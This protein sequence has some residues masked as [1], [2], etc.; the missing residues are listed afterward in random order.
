MNVLAMVLAGGEGTRLHPLTAE[1]SKPAVTF[2]NGCRIVDFVLSNLVN[3]G[4]TTIYLLAQYKPESLIE[5]ID[6]AW[7]GWARGPG[8]VMK[9][10]LPAWGQFRGT[11]DAVYQNIDL[12]EEHRPDVVAVFASDHV[13]RMDVR[14]MV[15]F[16][17][18]CGAEVTVGAVPVPLHDACSFGVIAV[19]AAGRI[20]E[21]QEKP[22]VPAPMPGD[23]DCAYASM[24]NYLFEPH[25]LVGLL[26]E[27][28]RW[29]RTDFGRDIMPRLPRRFRTFAYDFSG[30]YVPGLAAYEDPGYWRDVGT[31]EA[32]AAAR[33]DVAGS[34]PAFNLSN[35]LWP[36]RGASHA[37]PVANVRGWERETRH[38]RPPSQAREALRIAS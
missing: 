11:A 38:I 28:A 18:R 12:I 14:R 8:R 5:H 20:T 27:A 6:T 3:S 22:P 7:A 37:P 25:V 1:H 35:L 21:F 16:H 30:N 32:L 23:P 33:D 13:Y 9:V 19:D 2:V 34:R 26:E 17:R 10:V 29:G 4:V 24:G 36:I 31:L 15:E